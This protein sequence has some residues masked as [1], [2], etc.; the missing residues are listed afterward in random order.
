[1]TITIFTLLAIIISLAPCYTAASS[2]P[3]CPPSTMPPRTIRSTSI[4][5]R[6]RQEDVV[7]TDAVPQLEK[8]IN[9]INKPIAANVDNPM[10]VDNIHSLTVISPMPPPNPAPLIT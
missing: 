10:A 1:M 5:Q 4:T 6:R 3:L 9:T 8:E 7:M 2:T